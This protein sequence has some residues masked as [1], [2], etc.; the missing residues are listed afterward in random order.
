MRIFVICIINMIKLRRLSWAGHI[1]Q[2]GERNA[3]K[4]FIVKPEGEVT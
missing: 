4:V 3:C 1:V 2:M